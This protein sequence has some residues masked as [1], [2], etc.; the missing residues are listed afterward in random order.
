MAEFF[1]IIL[2]GFYLSELAILKDFNRDT[3]VQ[4]FKC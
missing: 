1:F 3:Y 2:G 4:R